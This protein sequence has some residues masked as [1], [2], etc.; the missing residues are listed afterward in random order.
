MKKIEKLTKEQQSKFKEYVDKW[1]KIG[2]STK[3]INIVLARKAV[4]EA[5]I[6]AGLVPPTNKIFVKSVSEGVKKV[7]ELTGS[8]SEPLYGSMDAGW[9]SFYDYFLNET[10]VKNIEKITGL[11]NLAK[12]CGWVWTFDNVAI[13]TDRPSTIKFD[14][15]KRLHSETGPAIQYTDGT[16][17][18]CWHG[19]KIPSKW[20]KN[21]DL[22]LPEEA[23]KI[24][25]MD[26]RKAACEIL[27]WETILKK[28]NGKVI[29]KNKDP[30]IGTLIEAEIP[31]V[32]KERFLQVQCGTGRKFSLIV[33]PT[34]NTAIEAN[35]WTYNL[36]AKEYKPEVRT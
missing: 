13:I 12:E 28:L 21:K 29:D 35:A 34:V 1:L 36:D 16:S 19:V 17:I 3:R 30:Q 4:D 22:L 10:E 25:N 33:P 26:Q 6:N 27:G 20:I 24:V 14:D 31:G 15:N 7:K 8:Y 23:L 18:Y 32:G 5:Y 9:L 11:I 2:L